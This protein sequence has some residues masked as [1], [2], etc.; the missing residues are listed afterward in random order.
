ME[1]LPAD[2]IRMIAER[3]PSPKDVVSFC[4]TDKKT[5]EQICKSKEFWIRRLIID[6]PEV[7]EPLMNRKLVDPKKTYER[8]YHKYKTEIE[9]RLNNEFKGNESFFGRFRVYKR[10]LPEVAKK[11]ENV[12]EEI[13]QLKTSNVTIG[14]NPAVRAIYEKYFPNVDTML[15]SLENVLYTPLEREINRR[16]LRERLHL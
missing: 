13:L 9:N 6:Y 2:V 3:L 1:T 10:H 12:Y 8:T 7:Y 14:G 5:N 16:V 4:S 15:Y 11:L